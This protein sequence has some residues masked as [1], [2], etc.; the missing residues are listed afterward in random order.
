MSSGMKYNTIHCG[1]QRQDSK[2]IPGRFPSTGQSISTAVER[3]S[4]WNSGNHLQNGE[5]TLDY[6]DG[7]NPITW[8]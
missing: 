2:D 4:R 6:I 3:L 7:L 1:K 8:L 5:T